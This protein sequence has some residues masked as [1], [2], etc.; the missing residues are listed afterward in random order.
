LIEERLGHEDLIEAAREGHE[1]AEINELVLALTFVDSHLLFRKDPL[2][3]FC[4]I[5]L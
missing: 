1:E 5:S 2:I 3:S 4:L